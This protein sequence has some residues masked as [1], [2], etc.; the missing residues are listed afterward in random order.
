METRSILIVE[1]E[2]IA[3]QD[4]KESLQSFGY[5][6]SGIAKSGEQAIRMADEETPDLILMDI[7]L[8]GNLSGIEA[9]EQILARHAVPI[10]YVTAYSNPE[11]TE[12]AKRTRPYG[13]IIKPYDERLIRTEIEIAL[14]KFGLDQNFRSEYAKLEEWIR[15]RTGELAEANEALRQSEARLDLALRS[16]E[17]GVWNWDIIA[18]KRYFDD[19]TCHLLGIDPVTFSGTAEEFFSV[20]HPE[21]REMVKEALNRTLEQDVL[22][23]PVYRAVWPDGSIRFITARGTMEKTAE[24]RPLRIN[25]LI[26]DTTDRK[27]AEDALVLASKKL[28][29]LSSI[30]RHDIRNQ[31]MALHSY[32]QLS[33]EV[34]DDPVE[35][36]KFIAREEKVAEAIS[37]Q[38]SFTK[39][40]EDL[41]VKAAMWQDVSV[42]VREAGALHALGKTTLEIDCPGLLVFAD[43]LLEKVFFN[44]IDNALRYGGEAMTAIHVTA[45]VRGEVLH[46]VVEDNGSGVSDED[47]KRLF[48]KGFGRN[49]G[50]GLFLS[51]E[52][53]SITGITITEN[54]VPGKGARFEMTVPKGGYRFSG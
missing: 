54:G 49:T 42:L 35:M 44:L 40:Y 23:E 10:I 18:D 19:Q 38:I 7:H 5:H 30:T 32:I 47:K 29:L 13:Y 14:Y 52:I 21:D 1:D 17:M 8:S 50:L 12:Q 33:E 27:R 24:G 48:T 46:I 22:Y 9:A 53:L 11:L 51:R 25:G 34:V 28:N 6:I 20:I 43:P 45:G 41:G 15:K 36:R 2:Q 3:A 39:D 31:L 4:L 16:A 37:R 26:W